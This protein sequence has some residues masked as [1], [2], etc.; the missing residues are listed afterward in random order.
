VLF[1]GVSVT[2]EGES[3]IIE[4]IVFLGDVKSDSVRVEV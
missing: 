4:A 2:T 1:G 3:Q